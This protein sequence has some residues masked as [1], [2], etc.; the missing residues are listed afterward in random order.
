MRL[1]V[2]GG[3]EFVGRHIVEA[4]LAGDDEVTLFNRGKTN[5]V[6]F[7]EATHLVG[8]RDGD[9]L[10]LEGLSFDAAIDCS[11]YLPRQVRATAQLLKESVRNYCFISSISVYAS[12]AEPGLDE[13]SPLAVLEDPDSENVEEDYGGL[14][15]LCEIEVREAFE[16][17]ALIVR[18]GLIVGPHDPTNRFT[19]WVRRLAEGGTVLAPGVLDRQVQMID[20]RDLADW[21]VT[22][23]P[24][25]L[26]GTFNATGPEEL[27]TFDEMLAACETAVGSDAALQWV[28]EAFLLDAGVEPWSELPVWLPPGSEGVLAVDNSKALTAGLRFRPLEETA[29]DTYEWVHS[30]DAPPGSAGL[31]PEREKELLA[32][33]DAG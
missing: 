22:E 4:A 2:L 18:P 12:F 7:P 8:D 10:A 27:M 5:P 9:L 31:S 11:G 20:A 21:V 30:L 24:D 23:L 15:A 32:A 29:R 33:W 1:L 28:D 6:L 3:T 14:K 13:V 19:Y 25:E 16:D 26:S 17:A